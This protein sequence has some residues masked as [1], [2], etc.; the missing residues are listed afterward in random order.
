[1]APEER[2][3]DVGIFLPANASE[4]CSELESLGMTDQSDGLGAGPGN[5]HWA[6]RVA[7]VSMQELAE[8]ENATDA[9]C[10]S[11]P[12]DTSPACADSSIGSE[13]PSENHVGS[14]AL[15]P[16]VT[17]SENHLEITAL[18]SHATQNED[19]LESMALVPHVTQRLRYILI[20]KM[21]LSARLLF[22]PISSLMFF[23]ITG[24]FLFLFNNLM[25]AQHIFRL[26]L[27]E[28]L[29]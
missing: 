25:Y 6:G 1:M 19:P 5:G 15:V 28:C 4:D 3:P 16:L 27:S 20:F 24:L 14:M 21:D 2:V 13:L 29:V 12:L 11:K 22:R 8:E 7:E 26:D 23:T 10:S 9:F 18:V 17:P